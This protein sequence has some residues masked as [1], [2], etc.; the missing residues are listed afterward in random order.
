MKITTERRR[1]GGSSF[2]KATEDVPEEEN[3]N[4]AGISDSE[5]QIRNSRNTFLEEEGTR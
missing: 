2:A 5:Y 3:A 4:V 1:V